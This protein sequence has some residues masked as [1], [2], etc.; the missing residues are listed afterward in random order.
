LIQ[1]AGGIA[2]LQMALADPGRRAEALEIL[3]G[4]VERVVLHPHREGLR[5]RAVGEI[6]ANGRSG[7]AAQTVRAQGRGC[8]GSVA[9]L[10]FV[11]AGVRFA[12]VDTCS[13]FILAGSESRTF[14]TGSVYRN[15]HICNNVQS[16]AES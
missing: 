3:R 13:S 7:R 1:T 2:D 5:D 11:V 14:Y 10:G 15:V 8:S 9:A 6:A 4:L 16:P 12:S